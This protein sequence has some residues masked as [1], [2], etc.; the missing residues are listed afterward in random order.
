M[1][2]ERSRDEKGSNEDGGDD[3]EEGARG[4][5][6]RTG[7]GSTAW[8]LVDSPRS[9]SFPAAGSGLKDSW[10]PTTLFMSHSSS[11]RRSGKGKLS[12]REVD[13]PRSN[14]DSLD[15]DEYLLSHMA[16]P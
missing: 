13:F 5:R 9:V 10:M 6:E 16:L 12:P 4:S 3:E 8:P 7:A 15:F 1:Q 2:P 11:A 14:Y